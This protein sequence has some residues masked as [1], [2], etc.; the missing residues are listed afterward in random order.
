MDW[1][2]H[3]Y[4]LNHFRPRRR[5]FR[6]ALWAVIWVIAAPLVYWAGVLALGAAQGRGVRWPIQFQGASSI[7]A[8]A[9]IALA[10]LCGGA[11]LWCAFSA[12]GALGSGATAQVDEEADWVRRLGWLQFEQLVE[13]HFIQRGMRVAL[14]RDMP[15]FRAR[16]SVID[17]NGVTLLIHY[18]DWKSI[19]LGSDVVQGFA[20][21]IATR[22][23]D[24][25]VLLT[26]GRVTRA[27]TALA[28]ENNIEIV[29]GK[30]L[31]R[32]LRSSGWDSSRFK[33]SGGSTGF[34]VTRSPEGTSRH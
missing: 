7:L 29:S 22:S 8:L 21:E 23:A 28:G 18:A 32:I 19:E 27:A 3:R 13:H 26:F 4:M 20:N 34:G 30:Q 2:E 6:W 9:P 5:A 1:S 24:S 31:V 11:S 25:G 15:A 16:L 14:L 33:E 17:A 12:L 10:A